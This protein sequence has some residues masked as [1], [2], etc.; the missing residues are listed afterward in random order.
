MRRRGAVG[1][2]HVQ[3]VQRQVGQQA[4]ELVLVAQQPQVRLG[5]HRLQQAA[6]HQ[7]GQAVGDAHRQPQARRADRLAQQ[8]GQLLAELEDLVGL[9]HRR[10]AGLGQHQAAPGRLEQRMAERALQLAHLGADG[11]HRHAEPRGG[12][13]DAAFLGDDPEV[14]QMPVVEAQAHDSAF[15]E[16]SFNNS[17]LF[18]A[19]LPSL[20]WG[21]LST[22]G[23][24]RC[25]CSSN[26]VTPRRASGARSPCAVC[27]SCCAGSAWL[28]PRARVQLFDVNGPRGGVDKQCR[29]ELKTANAGTV[30]VTA[31]ARDWHEA[32]D[33][34]LARRRARWCA[35]GGAATCR[36]GRRAPLSSAD[37]RPPPAAKVFNTSESTTCVRIPATA[38]RPPRASLRWPCSP[39]ATSAGPNS[40][41]WTASARM[42]SWA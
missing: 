4:V 12:A 6:H 7:L 18:Q 35:R 21:L 13:R 28:V 19:S 29:V 37:P 17:L 40:R 20:S 10:Q 24:M 5:Q 22:D 23:V 16:E 11:L 30:V 34:A 39:T 41:R 26:P 8:L 31:M 32:L 38:R 9:A 36:N 25:K 42:P 14:V 3:P 27:A 33:T 2:H 15:T 1:Q